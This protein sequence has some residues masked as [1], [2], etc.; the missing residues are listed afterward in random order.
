MSWKKRLATITTLSA[1]TTGTI[2]T[3]NKFIQISASLD[4]L[5]DNPSGFYYEWKF[6]KIYYTKHGEGEPI[7][8]IHDLSSQSSLYE[9][10]KIVKDLSK[11]NSVY[12]IDLLGCGRSDKPNITYTNF[13]YVQ[14][15]TDFIKK[16]IGEKC[17]IITSGL[18]CSFAITICH[19]N[20]D[21][22]NRIAMVNP[23]SIKEL[24]LVP[25]KRSKM[26]S[27]FINLPIFG[28]FLY[29]IIMRENHIE[30]L[31]YDKYF[32]DDK[33]IRGEM[34]RTYYECAHSGGASAKHLFASI[35][36]RYTTVNV[37]HCLKS[38][39]NSIFIIHGSSESHY[40][41]TGQQYK[42]LLPA[43]ELAGIDNTK[44]LPHMEQPE[45][46]TEQIH[47]LF[48]E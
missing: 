46:F 35:T 17:D 33:K 42:D 11:T 48:H 28:T 10:N 38:L 31:F 19:M 15:I 30:T 18:S 22:V 32:Y 44:Y 47:I 41:E 39:T 34:V 3:I 6:G 45:K 9:W 8:L 13:L 4:N 26:L 21:I 27:W 16:V 29:N 25:T 36:G 5:L 23:P 7:L 37:Y 12:C 2:Y 40:R 43:V 14:L 20:E 1:L 24:N